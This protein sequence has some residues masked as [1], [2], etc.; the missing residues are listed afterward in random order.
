MLTL[1]S[2]IIQHIHTANGDF[3]DATETDSGTFVVRS[4]YHGKH[5]PLSKGQE[6]L[7]N[8]NIPEYSPLDWFISLGFVPPERSDRWVKVDAV[9]PRIKRDTAA[10][11]AAAYAQQQQH[12]SY[13]QQQYNPQA[14][15]QPYPQQHQQQQHYSAATNNNNQGWNSMGVDSHEHANPS[16]NP[17]N[18]QFQQHQ[19]Q[20]K[21][22]LHPQTPDL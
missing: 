22:F 6:L 11:A 8:Y 3:L 19:Q 7:A 20:Q 4:I 2:H 15:N 10:Q 5:R 17:N 9:L 12:S 13:N 18:N 1:L 16:N 21:T 14:P